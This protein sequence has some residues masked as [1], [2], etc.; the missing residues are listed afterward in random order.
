MSTTRK[1]SYYSNLRASSNPHVQQLHT[2]MCEHPAA[3]LIAVSVI[4]GI[5]YCKHKYQFRYPVAYAR[6]NATSQVLTALDKVAFAAGILVEGMH[7]LPN[8]QELE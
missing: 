3:K 4:Y 2:L 8:L 6:W 1:S 5:I 7:I